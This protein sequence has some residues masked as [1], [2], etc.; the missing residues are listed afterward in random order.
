MKNMYNY[1]LENNIVLFEE[2]EKEL[3][4]R[5]RKYSR[6][7]GALVGTAVGS[8]FGN[9]DIFSTIG[10]GMLGAVAGDVIYK[11]FLASGKKESQAAEAAAKAEHARGNNQKAMQ[12]KIKAKKLRSQ[13]K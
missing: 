13:G 3:D 7:G 1:L 10:G 11:K 12:F 5:M 8:R 6:V 9:K 4:E 2:S